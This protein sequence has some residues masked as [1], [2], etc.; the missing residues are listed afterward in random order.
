MLHHRVREEEIIRT[1][2]CWHLRRGPQLRPDDA[3]RAVEVAGGDVD[4]QGQFGHLAV[5]LHRVAQPLVSHD[6][7]PSSDPQSVLRSGDEEYQSDEGVLEHVLEGVSPMV[8]ETFWD[9]ERGVVEDS[10]E[11][12]RVTLG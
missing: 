8:A 12:G 3:L 1:R 9:G 11:S 10:H 6:S 5:D 4:D 2:G 7:C